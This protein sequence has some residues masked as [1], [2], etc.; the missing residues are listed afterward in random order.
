MQESNN[1]K[2]IDLK[3]LILFWTTIALA[4]TSLILLIAVWSRFDTIMIIFAVL[5]VITFVVFR[6][7]KPALVAIDTILMAICIWLLTPNV[8][9][10]EL[11]WCVWY[12]S[13]AVVLTLGQILASFNYKLRWVQVGFGAVLLIIATY[14][15]ID[16]IYNFDKFTQQYYFVIFFIASH[17]TGVF[18]IKQRQPKPQAVGSGAYSGSISYQCANGRKIALCMILSYCTCGIYLLFWMRRIIRTVKALNGEEPKWI[19]EMLAIVCIPFYGALWGYSRAKHIVIGARKLGVEM[20]DSSL[21]YLILNAFGLSMV[22]F[23]LMQS[24]LDSAMSQ[25]ANSTA[26][27]E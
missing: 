15:L 11:L 20:G 26:V 4:V 12:I 16:G 21:L 9:S 1:K 17:V 6:N 7:I 24:E 14:L 2:P 25:H 10:V 19:G 23:A 13:V 27:A 18:C 3:K 22:T 8:D 5:S